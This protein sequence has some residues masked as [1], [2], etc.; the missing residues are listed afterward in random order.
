M[1]GSSQEDLGLN[2]SLETYLAF[3]ALYFAFLLP[4]ELRPVSFLGYANE[5]GLVSLK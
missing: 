1:H 5:A 4:G 3:N 2:G